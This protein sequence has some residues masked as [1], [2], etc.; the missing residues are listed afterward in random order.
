MV[1]F[2]LAFAFCLVL[3]PQL[4]EAQCGASRVSRFN[5]RRGGCSSGSCS[6]EAQAV[7]PQV[8][9]ELQLP[10]AASA[11]TSASASVGTRPAFVIAP[12]GASATVSVQPAAP[13]LAEVLPSAPAAAA[14]A[15]VS[16]APAVAPVVVQRWGLRRSRATSISRSATG[17]FGRKRSLSISSTRG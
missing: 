4:A 2:V 17:P 5:V 14:A 15:S 13:T 1:R 6:V 9:P 11:A 3:A 7:T 8:L 10:S 12:P 16:A